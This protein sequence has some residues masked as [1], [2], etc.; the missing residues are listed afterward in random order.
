MTKKAAQRLF[1]VSMGVCLVAGLTT[2]IS[3]AFLAHARPSAPEPAL[4]RIY[5]L[6]YHGFAVYVTKFERR[7]AGSKLVYLSGGSFLIGWFTL[8]LLKPFDSA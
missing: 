2:A 3:W 1:F 4:G 8:R 6:P 7:L 5:P